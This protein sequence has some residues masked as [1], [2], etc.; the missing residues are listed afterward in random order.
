M[1]DPHAAS[2]IAPD[3][4]ASSGPA[5]VPPQVGAAAAQAAQVAAAQFPGKAADAV[6]L[7][8]DTIHDKAVRPVTLAARAVV[9]GLIVAAMTT[10]LVVT[11]SIAALRLLDNYAFPHRVWLSYAVIGGLFTLAG[12]GAWT[13]RSARPSQ[14]RPG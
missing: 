12:L 2:S 10:V 9:F 14:V 11:G 7:L 8:V 3:T 1:S 13:R 6:Q 5:T 4:G